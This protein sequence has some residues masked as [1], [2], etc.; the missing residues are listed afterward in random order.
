[1]RV[2]EVAIFFMTKSFALLIKKERKNDTIA[3]IRTIVSSMAIT[4]LHLVHSYLP[5]FS[6][7]CEFT[8]G[9]IP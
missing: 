7:A 1:M 6:I 4:S 3:K 8:R 2:K 5:M 9:N